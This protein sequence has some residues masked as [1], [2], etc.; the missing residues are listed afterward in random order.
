MKRRWVAA[1]AALIMAACSGATEP[2]AEATSGQVSAGHERA[3]ERDDGVEITGL[4]GTIPREAVEDALNP[5]MGRFM[6]C[7]EQR[8]GEVEFLAGD[9]RL[10]FRIR[11]DGTVAWVYPAETSIGDR[12]AERCVLDVARGTRFRRPS[13]GEAEFSWGFGFDAPDDVRPPLNWGA[14][15]LGDRLR[16]AAAVARACSASGSS[17]TVYIEPG[18]R[19]LSAGGSVSSPEAE[20][21]LDC[22]LEQV[23]GWT[24]PDPGSYA[25][26]VTF[27]VQ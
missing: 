27:P 11:T 8:L 21:A 23:R 3:R 10:A 1:C 15:V 5:R 26:K 6:R 25:A 9:I 18:G 24:M 12:E 7:F 2:G 4:M 17:I 22:I 20:A 16:D 13:G 19:V 14:D